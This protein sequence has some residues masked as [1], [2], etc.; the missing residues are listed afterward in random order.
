MRLVNAISKLYSK[1]INREI[2]PLNEILITVGAY[3]ALFCA[4]QG[5]IEPGD[6]AIIIE[7]FFDCY[8]PLIRIAGGIPKFITLRNV[9]VKFKQLF[10]FII[11]ISNKKTYFLD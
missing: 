4:V 8:E 5:N 3:E 10:I 1:L 7:P 2:D 6:E 9:R 11:I